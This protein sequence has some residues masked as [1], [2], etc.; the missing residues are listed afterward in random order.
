MSHSSKVKTYFLLG[1]E[2]LNKRGKL[3]E[4]LSSLL[5]V[6]DLSSDELRQVAQRLGGVKNLYIL[7]FVFF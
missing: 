1:L 5:V 6:F 7:A 2:A 3:A 4:D